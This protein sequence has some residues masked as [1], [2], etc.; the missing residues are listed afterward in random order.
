VFRKKGLSASLAGYSS[1]FIFKFDNTARAARKFYAR[2]SKQFE[3]WCE[4]Y[5]VD[6]IK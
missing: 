5:I 1:D 3:V 2:R 6:M 4:G